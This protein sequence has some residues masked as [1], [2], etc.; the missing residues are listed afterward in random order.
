MKLKQLTTLF[1]ASLTGIRKSQRK[2][3]ATLIYG[4]MH[5]RRLGLAAIARYIPG[6][7]AKRHHI[8]RVDRFLG[9]ER[10]NIPVAAA[11]L[12][13]W[14]A[15]SRK[16]LLITLDWTDLNDS[17]HM[18]LV[19]GVIIKKRAIPVLWTVIKKEDL[20]GS[21]N[22]VEENLLETLKQM[23]PLETKCVIIADRGF[24]RVSLFRKLEKLGFSYVIRV[25]SNVWIKSDTYENILAEHKAKRGIIDFGKS[26]YQKHEQYR[27]RTIYC[28]S[29]GQKEPWFLVTDLTWRPEKICRTYGYRMRVE[30]FFRDLKNDKTGFGLRGLKL[31]DAGRYE[32]LFLVLAYAYYFLVLIGILAEQQQLH[33]QLV[34][35]SIK[36]RVLGLWQVGYYALQL[37]FISWQ[38]V[39][40]HIPS[41]NSVFQNWG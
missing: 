13:S 33:R 39:E 27:V 6:P 10:I 40:V 22:Q 14:L 12:L 7:V 28:F 17:K 41:T 31:K 21:Q 35:S 11:P 34:S 3:L 2:T 26:L 25:K 24:A 36:R 9:N 8:K 32:R 19:C 23:M 30:E 37:G 16:I 4:L 20:V 29:P 5:S 18:A 1:I 15:V 38:Q